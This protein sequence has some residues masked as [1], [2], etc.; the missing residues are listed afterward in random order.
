MKKILIQ[1]Y[2]N[3][4]LGDDLF[5]KILTE[6]YKGVKWYFVDTDEK[7]LT[8][9]RNVEI[10]PLSNGEFIRTFYQYDAIVNIGGSIFIQKDR[11]P[12]QL[13]KRLFYALPLKLLKRN[14]I[15]M[16][17]NFGPYKGSGFPFLY[18]LYFR[19]IDSVSFRDT[20]SYNIFKQNHKISKANDL[21][22]GLKT[23]LVRQ[24]TGKTVGI[25]LM[26]L[27]GRED[28]KEYEPIYLKSMVTLTQSL[29]KEGFSV[30]YFS[31]CKNEG[32]ERVSNYLVQQVKDDRVTQFHYSGNIDEFLQAFSKVTAFIGLRFHSIILAILYKIPFYPIIYSEK[33][34]NVLKDLGLDQFYQ[35]I[36]NIHSLNLEEI[37][38]SFK[39]SAFNIKQVV[40]DAENHFSFLDQLVGEAHIEN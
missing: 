18:S 28:L 10:Q 34:L 14:V 31:F 30:K 7:Y 26:D 2:L 13:V 33:T 12:L 25:S 36:Q 24:S 39:Q 17:S 4:N 16:G 6:R 38:Q 20:K 19:L 29:L 5:F 35:E 27:S 21:V 11:W 40:K 1:G 23:N 32:D 37:N 3:H 8:P 15:V 22:F 9:F